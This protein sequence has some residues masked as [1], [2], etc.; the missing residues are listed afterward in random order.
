MFLKILLFPVKLVLKLL[1]LPLILLVTVV[2]ILVRIT[3]SLSYYAI[4]PLMLFILACCRR[5][6]AGRSIP[7]IVAAARSRSTVHRRLMS[8]VACAAADQSVIR[9]CSENM[10]PR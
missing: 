7:Q 3:I 1:V 2:N 5:S 6:A 4:A 10:T 8:A 9:C